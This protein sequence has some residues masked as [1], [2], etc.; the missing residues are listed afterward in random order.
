M[1]RFEHSRTWV[2]LPGLEVIRLMFI[3]CI[4]SM[5]AISGDAEAIVSATDSASVE[6]SR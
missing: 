2:R 5:I 6:V 3:V 4:E 1:N